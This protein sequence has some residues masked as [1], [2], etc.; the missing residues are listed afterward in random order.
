[1]NPNDPV[2]P[3]VTVPLVLGDTGDMNPVVPWLPKAH[4]GGTGGTR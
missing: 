1:M 3:I 4:V 2:K